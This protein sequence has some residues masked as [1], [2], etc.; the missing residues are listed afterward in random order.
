MLRMREF[1]FSLVTSILTLRTPSEWQECR[2]WLRRWTQ[3]TLTS[4]PPSQRTWTRSLFVIRTLKSLCPSTR[5]KLT[6]GLVTKTICPG[7]PKAIRK[8]LFSTFRTRMW[9]HQPA[10]ISKEQSYMFPFTIRSSSSRGKRASILSSRWLSICTE[11]LLKTSTCKSTQAVSTNV[12]VSFVTR[13]TQW[14]N[15]LTHRMRTSWWTQLG[16]PSVLGTSTIL[17]GTRIKKWSLASAREQ[18]VST[19]QLQ[20]RSKDQS[21]RLHT[22]TQLA[23]C[24]L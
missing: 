5:R 15:R 4:D 11:S 24:H 18:L 16:Q 2:R 22:K 23:N 14:R 1:Q 10:F 21:D 3:R 19:H 6:S 9:R 13:D 12:F 8:R 20:I 7:C 17:Q